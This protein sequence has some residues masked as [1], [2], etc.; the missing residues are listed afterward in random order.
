MKRQLVKQFDVIAAEHFTPK[1]Q[2]ALALARK[3]KYVLYGGAMGGGKSYWLRWTLVNL[4]LYYGLPKE[5]GGLGIKHVM[6]GLFCEDY[7]ALNDRHL[8]KINTEF[9]AELGTYKVTT[10]TFVLNEDLGGGVIAFRNLD[11]ASK[12]QSSEFGAIAV[13]ELTKNP[14][15][16]FD[17]LRT[18]LRWPGIERPRFLGAT[19]PGSIGSEWVKRMWIEHRFE[20]TEQEQKEF[21]YVPAKLSD[22]PHISPAYLA[23]LQGMPEEMR[24]AFVEGDW[25][26]FQGQY[27]TEWRRELHTCAPKQILPHY[28]KFIMGDYG[29]AKPSAV[30]WGYVDEDGVFNIYRELYGSGM[31]YRDLGKAIAELT[32]ASERIDF[33]VFDPAIWSSKGENDELLNG[34]DLLQAG[35]KSVRKDGMTLVRGDNHRVVGWNALRQL[36]RPVDINGRATSRL[37]VWQNCTDLMRTMPTLVYDQKNPEDLDSDGEDHGADALRYGV[38]SRPQPSPGVSTSINAHIERMLANGAQGGYERP[39]EIDSFE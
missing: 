30:Y 4:L 26:V 28:R 24:R 22:N 21:V 37:Q 6:V 35:W 33:A 39:K 18:R 1:Q 14:K 5:K 10:H 38:M 31:T 3:Y 7:P 23:S 8:S 20:D 25:D 36:M 9:P 29:Y 27:F 11:D 34:A 13:D 12:Y 15:E 16:T 32:P 2:E 19:N 17:F